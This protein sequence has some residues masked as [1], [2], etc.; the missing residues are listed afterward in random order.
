MGTARL[1]GR[2]D[3]RELADRR[4]EL[5]PTEG[6]TRTVAQSPGMPDEVP[7]GMPPF[8]YAHESLSFMHKGS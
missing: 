5:T 1:P 4:V 6:A 2:T 3:G 8:A 7:G